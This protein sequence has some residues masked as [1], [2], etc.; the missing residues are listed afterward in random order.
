[1]RDTIICD[2]G[3][4]EKRRFELHPRKGFIDGRVLLR[5]S[6]FQQMRDLRNSNAF[7]SG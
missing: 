5:Y 6:V 1:M 2:N 4:F 3:Q 7:S